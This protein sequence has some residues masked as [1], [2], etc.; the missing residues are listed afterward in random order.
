M[1]FRFPGL[2][3]TSKNVQVKN[4]RS[5]WVKGQ[6]SVALMAAQLEQQR[7]SIVNSK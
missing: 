3:I 4:E 1:G 5:P 2:G 7:W 6:E